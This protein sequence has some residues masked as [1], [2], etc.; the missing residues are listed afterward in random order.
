M[1]T[2]LKLDPSSSFTVP[3]GWEISDLG[4]P[5]LGSIAPGATATASAKITA[6]NAAVTGPIGGKPVYTDAP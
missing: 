3:S 2:A 4:G 6:T 5:A 1:T